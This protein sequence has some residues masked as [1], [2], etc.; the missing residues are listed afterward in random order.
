MTD[1]ELIAYAEGR[2]PRADYLDYHKSR[3]PVMDEEHQARLLELNLA[4]RREKQTKHGIEYH[5]QPTTCQ[6]EWVIE[7]LQWKRNG[8]FVD[9]GA[10]DGIADSNTAALEKFFGWQGLCVEAG[11]SWGQLIKNRNRDFCVHACIDVAEWE[12]EFVSAGQLSGV[13]GDRT[14]WREYDPDV[15]EALI[16]ARLNGNVGI[17]KTMTIGS[18]L[19]L[20]MAPRVFDYLSLDIQ[21]LEQPVIQTFPFD[22]YTP[23]LITL[24]NCEPNIVEFL[25]SKGYRFVKKVM[26][27]GFFVHRSI[28]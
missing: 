10:Y 23:K 12:V 13:V 5:S 19:D 7:A 14:D 18:L 20:R 15:R 27:D 2:W 26:L 22:K 1:A 25:E 28:A 8:F 17:L 21:G 11:S 6:D 24:E 16:Q 4:R 9:V 3:V